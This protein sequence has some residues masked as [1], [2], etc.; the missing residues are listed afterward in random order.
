LKNK[1]ETIAI[2]GA[3]RLGQAIAKGLVASKLYNP[4]EI[5]LTKRDVSSLDEFESNGYQVTSENE[6]AIKK[7]EVL[8][9]SVGPRDLETLLKSEKN[10]FS[11]SKHIIVST[12]AGINI[13]SIEKSIGEG[14][15]VVRIMPNVAIEK[16][17]SMT[18]MASNENHQKSLLIIKDIFESVGYTYTVNEDLIGPATALCGS[19]LAFFLRSIRAAAH[20]GTEIGFHAEEALLLAAQTAKGAASLVLESSDHPETQIDKVTT[21]RG[22]TIAGLN[23]MDHSGFTSAMINAIVK[24]ANKINEVK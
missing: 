11:S 19:G 23:E 8:I 12:V 10:N 4:S 21:P 17:Q 13:N 20:G 18:C 2:I 1:P 7:S 3:G 24:S 5:I 14:V 9:F 16:C 6:L 22:I 15:P